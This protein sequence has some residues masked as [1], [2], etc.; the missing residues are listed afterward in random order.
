MCGSQEHTDIMQHSSIL[1]DL[2]RYAIEGTDRVYYIP[3]FV[4]E[5]EET[6][7]MRQ[8]RARTFAASCTANRKYNTICHLKLISVY[9]G[10]LTQYCLLD[11]ECP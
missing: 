6:Y 1:S 7:L 11:R 8:V 3:E 4:S 5:E 9:H 2:S 10:L